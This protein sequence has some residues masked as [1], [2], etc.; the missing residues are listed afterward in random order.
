MHAGASGAAGM[1]A[2]I[3]PD[4]VLFRNLGLVHSLWKYRCCDKSSPA[5]LQAFEWLLEEKSHQ[6]A[7][8]LTTYGRALPSVFMTLAGPV[9]MKISILAPK[10]TDVFVQKHS[11]GYRHDK[12]DLSLRKSH[13]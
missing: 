13:H 11:M 12:S 3:S 10:Q 7:S 5:P 9:G 8:R 6:R 1:S 2:P 4:L